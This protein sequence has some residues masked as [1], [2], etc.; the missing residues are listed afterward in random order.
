MRLFSIML[1]DIKPALTLV[2]VNRKLPAA[3]GHAV[4]N[5]Y[6]Y[7]SLSRVLQYHTVTR[8]DLSYAIQ[9]ACLHMHDPREC[10][11]APIERILW[12]VRDTT[13]LG[14]HLCASSSTSL[15]AYTNGNWAGYPDTR[16]SMSGYYVFFGESLV[17][18][19]SKCQP[20]V[21]RSSVGA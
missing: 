17:S 7:Q 14:L 10:H 8:S 16:H 18:W 4:A 9:Q 12:Y 20:T 15:M 2:D 5:P 13:L 1:S 3:T 6:E 21:S 11:L 19:S